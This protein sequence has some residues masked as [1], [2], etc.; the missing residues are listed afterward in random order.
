[1]KTAR[2]FSE[3]GRIFCNQAKIKKKY[4]HSLQKTNV[5]TKKQ[6]QVLFARW[7]FTRITASALHVI[8]LKLL[9][10]S[11]YH[12]QNFRK[13][14]LYFCGKKMQTAQ[15]FP[16]LS[17]MTLSIFLLNLKL[18][19][20]FDKAPQGS[21]LQP[22]P[23]PDPG[24]PASLRSLNSRICLL[25]PRLQ[26]FQPAVGIWLPP[27]VTDQEHLPV[28]LFGLAHQ[29]GWLTTRWLGIQLLCHSCLVSSERTRLQ[30]LSKQ[31]NKSVKLSSGPKCHRLTDQPGKELP[32]YEASKGWFLR[33]LYFW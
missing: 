16:F 7:D 8:Q 9:Q 22:Q 4:D 11:V 32:I 2:Y 14:L 28:P 5:K 17:R 31:I 1:M 19:W 15:W 13:A 20:A 3:G 26:T 12:W 23:T 6:K 30:H 10:I 33:F 29:L 21:L 18:C 24:P 25:S 27:P